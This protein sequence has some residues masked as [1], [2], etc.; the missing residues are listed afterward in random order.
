MH[1]DAEELFMNEFD[2]FWDPAFMPQPGTPLDMNISI[3]EP[4]PQP[5]LQAGKATSF[6]QFSSSL[7]SLRLV[8]NASDTDEAASSDDFVSRE[9][10]IQDDEHVR[11]APWCISRTTFE[12]LREDVQRYAHLIPAGCSTPTDNALSRGLE[13]YLRCTQK[14]LPFIHVATFSAETRDV[15]MSLAMAALGFL[16]RFEHGK[17]YKLYFMARAI[18][19]EKNHLEHLQLASDIVGNLDHPA[20]TKS[21]KLRKIQTLILLITFGSWAHKKARTDAVSMAGQLASK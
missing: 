13:T 4:G 20:H 2:A 14:Y 3:S 11:P 7:P 16:Y 5:V 9:R 10:A 21:D 19:L 6:S 17:A 15:E 18:W 12:K 1:F 8:D